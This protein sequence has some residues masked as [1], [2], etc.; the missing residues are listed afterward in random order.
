[1]D[2]SDKY[3]KVETRLE[4][5]L[6][7]RVKELNCLYNLTRLIE[8]NENSIESILQGAAD[9]LP[10][11][12]Q[13]PEFARARILFKEQAYQSHNFR[14]GQ[15]KQQA[16]LMVFGQQLGRVEIHYLKNFHRLMKVRFSKKKDC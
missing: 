2:H 9:L 4:K 13:Y 7:E 1:M 5:Q 3:D 12:W 10:S 8:E 11:S 6:R 16:A 15:W 14:T